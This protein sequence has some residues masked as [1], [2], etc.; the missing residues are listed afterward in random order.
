MSDN[1]SPYPGPLH[2]P[3][4]RLRFR[5]GARAL[6]IVFGAKDLASEAFNF[7]QTA[8]ALE[9]HV[10]FVNNGAN[11]WYQDG[12]PG[13]GEGAAATTQM[14]RAWATALGVA[15]V[16]TLGTSMGAYGAIQYGAA[17]GARIL[18]FS[19]DVTLCAP[20][21]QSSEHYTGSGAPSC[22]DLRGPLREHRPQLTLYVGE[23]DVGDLA[24]AAA[25]AEAL[26]S[27]RIVSVLG[28]GHILPS[29]LTRRALLSPIMQA[30][31]EDR[32][33]PQ[34]DCAG[35][36]WTRGAYINHLVDAS[37]ALRAQD[38]EAAARAAEAA[39]GDL[40]DGEAALIL[41]GQ[42]RLR[43]G[44]V[45]GG[46]AALSLASVGAADDADTPLLLASG[47]RRQGKLRLARSVCQSVLDARPG[48]YQALAALSLVYEQEGRLEE[49][50]KLI[51]RVLRI[52]PGHKSYVT[53]QTRL[54]QSRKAAAP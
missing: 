24:S 45:E 42:A 35:I 11:H 21:S 40:P 30:V 34:L 18:A 52:V 46:V 27:A 17:L 49:A 51:A 15:D 26:P 2:G 37:F 6:V 12:V 28:A 22:G 1:D 50:E 3:C 8:R 16:V 53:I 39:L 54:R 43:L 41:L 13:L 32:E 23:R 10:L 29:F 7:H 38:F 25:I 33:P 19:T 5:E 36:A 20:G 31:L 44:D 4:H 47:L 14:M 48:S 9:A